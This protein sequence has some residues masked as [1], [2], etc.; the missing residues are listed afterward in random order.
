VLGEVAG[1][2]SSLER[3]GGEVNGEEEFVEHGDGLLCCFYGIRE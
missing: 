1:I 2:L 3:A